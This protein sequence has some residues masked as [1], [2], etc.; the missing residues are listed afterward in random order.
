MSV[1]TAPTAGGRRAAGL[2]PRRPPQRTCVACRSSRAKRELVRLVRS[3][4]GRIEVDP[5]GK[6]SGRGAY[7]CRRPECWQEALRKDRLS[8]ALR[9]KLSK[10]DREALQAEGEAMFRDSSLPERGASNERTS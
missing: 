9:T 7:L 3:A 1:Q 2:R 5:T 8:Y 4:E 10:T 6:K